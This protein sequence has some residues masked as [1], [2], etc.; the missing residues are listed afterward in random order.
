MPPFLSPVRPRVTRPNRLPVAGAALSVVIAA[1][2]CNDPLTNTAAFQVASASL[3]VTALSGSGPN[4][5]S[6]LLLRG[7]GA[8]AQLQ[9]VPPEV[10]N[11]DFDLAVDI[12]ASGQ[13]VLYPARLVTPLAQR[14]AALRRTGESYESLTRAPRGTY[15]ADSAFVVRVGEVLGVQVPAATAECPYSG[16]PYY[17][18]KIVVDSVNAAARLVYVRA[19]TDP[20]CGFRSFETGV[21]ES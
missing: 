9:V 18:S 1:A 16:S 11:G 2:A 21:P 15:T 17:Y 7:N 8:G 4:T 20:N 3:V 19:T 13:P 14:R 5:P 12:D 6:A 10:A